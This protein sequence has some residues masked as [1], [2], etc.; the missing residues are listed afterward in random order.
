V[1]A[2]LE[3]VYEDLEPG[4]VT[5]QLEETH[6]ADDAEKL[7]EVVLAIEPRQQEVEVE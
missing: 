2:R 6:D 5:R 3:R 4:R 7:E 1:R